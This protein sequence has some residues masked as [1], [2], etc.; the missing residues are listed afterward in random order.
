VGH[1]A[2]MGEETNVYRVQPKGR[3]HSKDQC[4]DGRMGSE[5]I[6][7][8][9]TDWGSVDWIQLTQD[10]DRWRALVTTVMN[11]RVLTPRR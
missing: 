6:L 4:V 1:V 3:D 2:C 7:G 5:W 11:I 9:L 10:R 8:R